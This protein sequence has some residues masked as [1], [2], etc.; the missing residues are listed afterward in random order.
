LLELQHLLVLTA[1]CVLAS[2][3]SPVHNIR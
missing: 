1:A 3:V 2:A